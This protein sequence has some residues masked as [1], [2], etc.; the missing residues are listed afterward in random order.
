[1]AAHYR[2]PRRPVS[3]RAQGRVRRHTTTETVGAAPAAAEVWRARRPKIFAAAVTGLLVV[4]LFAFFATD[5]FYVFDLEVEG[6]QFLS[7]AEVERASGIVGYSIFF[8]DAPAVERA[9]VKLPEARGARVTVGVPNRVRVEIDERVPEIV[10]QRGAENYWVDAAG[11]GFRART[12]LPG[13]PS[14][15]DVDQTPVTPGQPVHPP[16]RAALRALWEVWLDAPRAFEWSA[17]RGL[18]FTD[19]HG[20]KIYLGDAREMAGKVAKL[21]ALVAQLVAEKAKI[22][23]IDLGKGDPYYQ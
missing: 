10:W 23:F 21:R 18:A 12:D 8:V 20:W 14:L 19:E 1:M 9:L 22:R 5:F 6:T 11:I 3:R 13:L 17:A 15:R 7:K 2:T 16:A 4:A